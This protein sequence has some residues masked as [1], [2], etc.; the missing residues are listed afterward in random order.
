VNKLII[1][2]LFALTV[3]TPN[4]RADG[5][6]ANDVKI[7]PRPGNPV[8]LDASFRDETGEVVELGRYFGD[9]PVVLVLAYFRC[10]RLCT[11]V[12]NDMN[13][14]LR[15]VSPFSAGRDF[16]VVVVSFDAREKPALA[17]AKKRSY[18]EDYARPGAEAGWHFL[19]GEQPSIDRLKEAVGFRAVYDPKDDQFAHDSAIVVLTPAGKVSRYLFGLGY[20]PR[21]L[22]LAL[23]ES[24]EG[25]IGSVIDHVLLMCFHYDPS[26]GKYSAT[27]MAIVRA[28]GM[29]T[30]AALVGFWLVSA[31]RGGRAAKL[32]MAG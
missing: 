11:E 5:T 32:P 1:P 7:Q 26:T 4:T 2:I 22:R 9:K 25:K 8:P 20:N 29:L 17:A 18:V 14:A 3:A 13:K 27:V 6:S 15:G 19:T 16:Q 28:G 21:D 10:P 23:V 12:L 30:I 24:S 31:R